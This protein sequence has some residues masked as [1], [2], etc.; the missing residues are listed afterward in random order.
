MTCRKP[1]NAEVNTGTSEATGRQPQG[2]IDPHASV[3]GSDV[4][5]NLWASW[6]DQIS[7]PDHRLQRT[8][9]GPGGK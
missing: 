3:P 4:M 8:M 7:A 2:T 1:T 9:H 5:L 6:M